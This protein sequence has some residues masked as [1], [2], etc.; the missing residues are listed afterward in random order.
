MKLQLS[1]LRSNSC[2]RRMTPLGVIFLYVS[3]PSGKSKHHHPALKETTLP[4]KSTSRAL[5]FSSPQ[6]RFS[7]FVFQNRIP[8]IRTEYLPSIPN[9][10]RA[11]QIPYNTIRPA[12]SF[13]NAP[14]HIPA[15][16]P[17]ADNSSPRGSRINSSHPHCCIQVIA[18]STRCL[19]S[20]AAIVRFFP[21]TTADQFSAEEVSR[22]F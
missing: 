20:F 11:T 21:Y 16:E 3:I 6:D 15:V 14:R 12:H 22:P 13:R 1:V 2:H 9:I 17:P 7:A 19:A 4:S 10:A 5:E 8:T 18:S